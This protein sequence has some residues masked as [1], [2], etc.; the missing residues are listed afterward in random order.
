MGNKKN[1]SRSQLTGERAETK[2]RDTLLDAELFCSKY[3]HDRGEDL[4]VELE[5]YVGQTDISNGP[6]IGLLQIKGHE[7]EAASDSDES[8]VRRRLELNH[9][10]RWAAIPLP[11]FII[12]VDLVGDAPQFF[13]CPVDKLVG[14]VAPEGLAALEQQ[15][16]TVLLPRIVD[17]P[18]FLK[19][20]IAEFYSLHAFHISG[21]SENVIARNHYEI[22]SSN[23]PFVPPQAKV[24]QKNIRVLW[25]G[26]WRPAHF[27][28]TL[29]HIAD[30]IQEKEGARHVPLMA[31]MHIY[32][33]LK[34]NRD[35][36]AIAHV[37]WL[38]DKHSATEKLRTLINWPKAV[39][40]ARFRFH[41]KSALDAL[42][43]SLVPE[44]DDELFIT[45]AEIIWANL[46]AI[47]SAVNASLTSDLKLP[48]KELRRLEESLHE[49]EESVCDKLGWPSPQLSVLERMICQYRFVLSGVFTWL[50]GKEDVPEIRRKRW[51]RQDME[52][53][54]G[55]Y[56]AFQPLAMLLRDR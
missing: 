32:R 26:P 47:Y 14:D 12:A 1:G 33:S 22:I 15:T 38:E 52:L 46:D 34:D 56:R 35:N 6:R 27:W 48:E 11:V 36:N 9:L 4:L 55:H 41:G 16:I 53:A 42:P 29:N 25:K 51:L 2:V 5:G 20:E 13:A 24:W 30:Q 37:S 17:L 18:A 31:T 21:L 23:T 49:L 28:A 43:E 54:E 40:W 50:K 10:R 8:V 39:H 45:K 19:T 7:A 3:E 44:E